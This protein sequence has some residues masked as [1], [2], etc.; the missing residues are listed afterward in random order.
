[1]AN[2]DLRESMRKAGI[3]QWQ[4]AYHYGL[5]DGNFSRLLRIELPADKKERILLV[6]EQIKTGEV[7]A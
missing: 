4:V 6:I 1:V 7:G 3:R 5:S 2:A